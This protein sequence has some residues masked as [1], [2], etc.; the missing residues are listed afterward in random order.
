MAI[1]IPRSSCII[2][3]HYSLGIPGSPRA[4]F[5]ST[6]N[7]RYFSA[8][9]SFPSR[10]LKVRP[11]TYP[12]N[13]FPFLACDNGSSAFCGKLSVAKRE[14]QKTVFSIARL[15]NENASTSKYVHHPISLS[16]QP[17]LRFF[18]CLKR[19]LIVNSPRL[20]VG[21]GI[22][23]HF[24]SFALLIDLRPLRIA[25]KNLSN[26]FLS[27]RRTGYTDSVSFSHVT[28]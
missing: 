28:P 19:I 18:Q 15:F 4:G 12:R 2:I 22:K 17:P 8:G 3:H 10:F 1:S 24:Q 25:E 26:E 11:P 20:T 13:G 14:R 9:G 21:A 7:S 27:V 6:T 5:G 23:L 16:N